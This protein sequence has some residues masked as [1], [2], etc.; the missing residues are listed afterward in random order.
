MALQH[1]VNRWTVLLCSW[2]IFQSIACLSGSGLKRS[3]PC[4][5]PWPSGPS[6]PHKPRDKQKQSEGTEPRPATV[7][8]T[9]HEG[10]SQTGGRASR[11]QPVI[12]EVVRCDD[13]GM[14]IASFFFFSFRVAAKLAGSSA[15]SCAEEW[16]SIPQKV[17]QCVETSTSWNKVFCFLQ[18]F[19]DD[20]DA[21]NRLT[22]RMWEIL[23]C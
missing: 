15:Q 19:S 7:P 6:T 20:V 3:R 11:R 16:R 23:S 21:D 14:L 9:L 22:P 8:Y 5:R 10:F 12:T 18:L 13:S 4:S 2:S 17:N 1:K